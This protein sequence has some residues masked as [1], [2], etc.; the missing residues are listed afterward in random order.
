MENI[1]MTGGKVDRG[2][3]RKAPKKGTRKGKGKSKV[4]KE[5]SDGSETYLDSTDDEVESLN[6]IEVEM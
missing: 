6:C 3:Q 4:K 5:S 2:A 1:L